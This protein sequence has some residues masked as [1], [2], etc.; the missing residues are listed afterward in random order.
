MGPFTPLIVTVTPPYATAQ[1]S[2]TASKKSKFLCCI[3]LFSW[4]FYSLYH[5]STNAR[6]RHH[7]IVLWLRPRSHAMNI[8]FL[9]PL[10][11]DRSSMVPT[12]LA[13]TFE[14]KVDC[15]KTMVVTLKMSLVCLMASCFLRSQALRWSRSAIVATSQAVPLS[16]S[17][18]E[19]FLNTS[20]ADSSHSTSSCLLETSSSPFCSR[21]LRVAV[22]FYAPESFA[23]RVSDCW[24]I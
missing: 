16:R 18:V 21:A 6:P 19:N 13:G 3:I 15:W 22:S 12:R 10:N 20:T 9:K 24:R 14:P 4:I 23:A 11:E 17:S 8:I 2:A 7:S 1:Y 5:N